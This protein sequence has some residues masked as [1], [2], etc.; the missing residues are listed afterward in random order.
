MPTSMPAVLAATIPG[1][2][3]PNPWLNISL[4]DTIANRDKSSVQALS[5]PEK[6]CLELR[7]LPEPFHGNPDAPVYVLGKCPT[8]NYDD[9]NFV[10]CCDGKPTMV[11]GKLPN[12]ERLFVN[13]YERESCLELWHINRDFLWLRDPKTVKDNSDAPYPG[14]D[15][16]RGKCKMLLEGLG[17]ELC[18]KLFAIEYFPYHVYPDSDRVITAAQPLPSNAYADALIRRAIKQ[19]KPIVAMYYK[20][21]WCDRIPELKNYPNLIT[22]SNSTSAWLSPA[23]VKDDGWNKLCEAIPCLNNF[24]LNANKNDK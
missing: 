15:W 18:E 12:G 4:R 1:I 2:I 3:I 19:G 8:A 16:W 9:L 11:N 7:T 17:C 14:Y 21:E 6:D 20:T 5:Q 22:L 13:T 23:N 10:G 24:K